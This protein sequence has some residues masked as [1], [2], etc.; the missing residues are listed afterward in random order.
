VP[1]VT[2]VALQ[3]ESTGQEGQGGVASKERPLYAG[4]CFTGSLDGGKCR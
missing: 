1:V 4:L 3:L 2:P